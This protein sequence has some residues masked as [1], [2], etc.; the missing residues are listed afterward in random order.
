M[1]D[2]LWVLAVVGTIIIPF[3]VTSSKD[4]ESGL[5]VITTVKKAVIV[6]SFTVGI[7]DTSVYLSVSSRMLRHDNISGRWNVLKAFFAGDK[8]GVVSRALVKTG[9]LYFL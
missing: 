8:L 9:Q 7:F 3:S 2:I 5:C 6:P 4:I 1:L